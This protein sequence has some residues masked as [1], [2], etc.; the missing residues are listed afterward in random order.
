M[1]TPFPGLLGQWAGPEHRVHEK[2]WL[3]GIRS[4]PSPLPVVGPIAAKQDTV[5]QEIFS[6]ALYLLA[7]SDIWLC[8]LIIFKKRFAQIGGGWETPVK[9]NMKTGFVSDDGTCPMVKNLELAV[10]LKGI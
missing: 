10:S 2:A 5:S 3:P 7:Q 1:G 6:D 4:R 8:Q 9:I